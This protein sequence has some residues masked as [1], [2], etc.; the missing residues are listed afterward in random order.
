MFVLKEK[1]VFM[2]KI[3]LYGSGCKTCHKLKTL[4]E[5]LIKEHNIPAELTYSSDFAEMA[6]LGIMLTPTIV[7]N[8]QIK[9]TG[10]IPS[11]ETIL[12]W[13]SQ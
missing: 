8:N 6:K 12:S 3:I 7:V 13:F 4:I 5:D 2:H 11:S 1:G 9:T 10:S